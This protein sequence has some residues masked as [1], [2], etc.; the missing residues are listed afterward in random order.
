[1]KFQSFNPISSFFEVKSKAS[2]H[3]N[4]ISDKIFEEGYLESIFFAYLDYIHRTHDEKSYDQFVNTIFDCFENMAIRKYISDLSDKKFQGFDSMKEDL[5][6]ILKN[7]KITL[8]FHENKKSKKNENFFCSSSS[9][10]DDAEEKGEESIDEQLYYNSM[11]KRCL[12]N[13]KFINIIMRIFLINLLYKK[14]DQESLDSLTSLSNSPLDN[15]N[16]KSFN[17]L[18]ANELKINIFIYDQETNRK[19]KYVYSNLNKKID[20]KKINLL[21]DSDGSYRILYEET[22]FSMNKKK[23]LKSKVKKYQNALDSLAKLYNKSNQYINKILETIKKDKFK[24][25]YQ[26]SEMRQKILKKEKKLNYKYY[27]KLKSVDDN[28]NSIDFLEINNFFCSICKLNKESCDLTT[29]GC[30]CKICKNC[31]KEYLEKYVYQSNADGFNLPCFNSEC[32]APKDIQLLHMTESLSLIRELLGEKA[33]DHVYL[34][35][36]SSV[37]YDD[38]QLFCDLSKEIHCP[39]CLLYKIPENMI[40]FDCECKICDNCCKKYLSSYIDSSESFEIPC[41]KS[42]CKA[43]KNR[44]GLHMPQSLEYIK[45]LFGQETITKINSRL[46][47]LKM[48]YKCA[49]CLRGFE[50][51]SSHHQ[52][53]YI[54]KF[55]KTETCLIC[56][57]IGHKGKLCEQSLK[58]TR[59]CP[60]CSQAFLK[61]KDGSDQVYCSRCNVKFCHQ[62]SS[63]LSP[64]LS[65]GN[66]YHR[67]DCKY[68]CPMIDNEGNEDKF[69]L[70]CTECAKRFKLCD[71]PNQTLRQF[72]A[73]KGYLH[74]L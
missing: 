34:R 19:E 58:N 5:M 7:E 56:E 55:C 18:I 32:K 59:I 28:D 69:E 63:L 30:E 20:K 54:C 57:K 71:R 17:Q 36:K 66:Q 70:D 38:S 73:E 64:I 52:D 40:T 2:K 46:T 13:K 6:K 41:F 72:Y 4:S 50:L 51:N 15:N 39:V 61:K 37:N 29:F 68:Y 42:D 44:Q 67:K 48:K 43:I 3:F 24:E 14:K 62:C 22:L 27:L 21:R 65:H 31:C 47:A 11:K 49:N 26:I 12:Q 23:N 60:S 16:Y 9:E 35:P 45:R 74:Y 33:V 8:F 25:T 1:M 10:S 53:F